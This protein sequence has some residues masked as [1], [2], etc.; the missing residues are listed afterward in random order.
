MNKR[1]GGGTDPTDTAMVRTERQTDGR[2]R[3][4]RAPGERRIEWADER[5][6][7][8]RVP[9]KTTKYLRPISLSLFL[10]PAVQC[11]LAEAHP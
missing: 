2:A 3:R 9:K 7:G 6:G 4:E 10:S 8:R 11:R 5:E 1:R